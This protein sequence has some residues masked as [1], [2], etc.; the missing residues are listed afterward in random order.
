VNHAGGLGPLRPRQRGRPPANQ[1]QPAHAQVTAVS[2]PAAAD[3]EGI[4]LR[5]RSAQINLD[6]PNFS[7]NPTN[8]NSFAVRAAVGGDEG[9][10]ADLASH[11]Q[12][13]DCASLPF[14]PKLALEL[15]GA[16]SGPTCR[17]CTR[18]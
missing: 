11:F 1:G 9:G 5:L 10:R 2:G 14:G 17:R 13:A 12:V 7:L 8:C 16:P 18:P 15:K 4:P 6:R 3:V